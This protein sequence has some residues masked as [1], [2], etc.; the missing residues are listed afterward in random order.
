MECNPAGR[1]AEDLAVQ[2][3]RWHIQECFQLRP[4]VTGKVEFETPDAYADGHPCKVSQERRAFSAHLV[5]LVVA[6]TL[7]E[8]STGF[9]DPGQG[10]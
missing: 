3:N 8:S 2:Q 4:K 10:P 7:K 9:V 1:T 5:A 6:Y